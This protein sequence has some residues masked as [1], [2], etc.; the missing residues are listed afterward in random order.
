MNTSFELVYDKVPYWQWDHFGLTACQRDNYGNNPNWFYPFRGGLNGFHTRMEGAKYHY[1]MLHEWLP[2]PRWPQEFEYH[3]SSFFFNAD[4]AV[5]CLAFAL[6]ALG[7][8]AFREEF[9]SISDEA[10]LRRIRPQ[11]LL[12][13]LPVLGRSHAQPTGFSRVF[14]NTCALWRSRLS[15]LQQIFEQHDVSKHRHMI[16]VGGSGRTEDAP[17][18]FWE[19][20]NISESERSRFYPMRE[21]ILGNDLKKPLEQRHG[22]QPE[23]F[24]YLENIAPD[25]FRFA[26]DSGLTILADS[27]TNIPIQTPL[28]NPSS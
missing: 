26:S 25:F 19:G 27:V 16:Y 13:D 6:N 10:S 1:R 12:S 4:S 22:Q 15:L 20:L 14:S 24:V 8:A 7:Y 17:E 2:Q 11:L 28:T 23:E 3:L 5:E 21:V 18:G 9:L